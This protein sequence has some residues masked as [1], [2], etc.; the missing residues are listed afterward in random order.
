MLVRDEYIINKK[1][2]HE[3]LK[4]SYDNTCTLSRFVSKHSS[5]F[6]QI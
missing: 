1:I 4:I 3:A 5:Y 6:N 2:P